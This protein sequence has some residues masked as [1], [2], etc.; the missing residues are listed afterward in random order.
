MHLRTLQTFGVVTMRMDVQDSGGVQPA[1]PSASTQTQ[2]T[3][4]SSSLIKPGTA[5]AVNLSTDFGQEVEVHNL[6]I[7]DQHT[8]EGT[9]ATC[10]VEFLVFGVG[11]CY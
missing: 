8:F 11:V 1:R 5:G 2:S 10:E 9:L 6:L 7:I 3:S 4:V